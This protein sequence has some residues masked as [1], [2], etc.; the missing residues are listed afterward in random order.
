V[1]DYAEVREDGAIG[2]AVADRALSMLEVDV[3]GL[4][5]MD[6][7]LLAA[8]LDRFGGG[9]VGI[10]NLAAAIGEERDTLEDVVEPFLIQQGFLQRTPRGRI[11]APL[12]YEHF[13]R[14][15][16]GNAGTDRLL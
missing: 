3:R 12:A 2:R 10:E 13:G 16:P 1:R 11:A 5:V 9:P 14:I 7:K 8:I 4:D 6:R 15:A